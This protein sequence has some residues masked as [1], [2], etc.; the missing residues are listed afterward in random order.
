MGESAGS[1]SLAFHLSSDIPLFSRVI[2]Q[3]GTAVTINPTSL[4]A[5]EA[6]YQALL[7]YCG[8]SREDPDRI[9]KLQA[10]PVDKIVKAANHLNRGAFSPLAHESFFPKVPSYQNHTDIIAECSWLESG[11]IGDS[12]FE[13]R[14][15]VLPSW[16]CL[17]I[18]FDATDNVIR[19]TSSSTSYG[20]YPQK[21]S[22]RT[23]SPLWAPAGRIRLCLSTILL[24]TWIRTSSGC[25]SAASLATSCSQ[26]CA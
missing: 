20:L 5:K 18:P 10:V 24:R 8:I 1:A 21:H 14:S 17:M 19:A 4:E 6:E 25:V 9:N 11:V 12:I 16:N 3:S 2:L 15:A 22:A 13:V 26:V 7:Q 23:S